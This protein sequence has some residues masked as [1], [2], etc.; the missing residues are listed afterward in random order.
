VESKE[1]GDF[2]VFT[3]KEPI[4]ILA[5]KSAVVPMFSVPL[6]KAGVVLLYKESN[7]ARRPFRTVKF[8]NETDFSLGKGKTVIYNSGL[9]SGECVLDTTKP[10]ENR[11]LPHCLENSVK[12]VKEIKPV[13]TKRQALRISEGVGIVEDVYTALT[14]YEVENKK[15]EKF[16]MALEHSNVLNGYAN[17][18]VDFDGVEVKEREKLVDGNGYRVYFE[19]A[20][21]QKVKLTVLENSL[22]TV[23]QHI[24]GNFPWLT[25]NIISV[26]NPLSADKQ[27]VACMK[28]QQ[29]IDDVAMKINEAKAR[30]SELTEQADRVRQN[31]AAAKDM[32]N[33]TTINKWVADLDSTESEIRELDKKTVPSLNKKLKELQTK[34]SEEIKKISASWKA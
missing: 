15:D 8:K 5:R 24:G 34:L 12:V 32:G 30:R 2:C 28:V 20:P 21:K 3:S 4:T 6:T 22:N 11:M 27:V 14:T 26:K 16:S 9:F 25:T 17:L 13:Q 29:D 33:S 23:Q 10:G 31:L 18:N 19:L 7:H 1:V